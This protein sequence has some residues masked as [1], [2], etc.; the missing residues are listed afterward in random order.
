MKRFFLPLLIVA[1]CGV[2][3]SL[4]AQPLA[5]NIES[6]VVNCEDNTVELNLTVD[7]FTD[8]TS[9]QFAL[10]CDTSVLKFSTYSVSNLL[11]MPWILNSDSAGIGQL[12]FSW[13]HFTNVATPPGYSVSNGTVFIT[14]YFNI[15]EGR[16]STPI[17]FT[18]L[19]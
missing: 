14:L 1:F 19:P 3:I 2:F 4:D 12:R 18:G 17:A 6:K 7:E 5:F 16:P 13:V 9:F 11:P 15:G 8:I 10:T